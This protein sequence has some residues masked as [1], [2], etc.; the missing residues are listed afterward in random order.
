MTSAQDKLNNLIPIE[1]NSSSSRQD[2]INATYANNLGNKL[3]YFIQQLAFNIM[4]RK[5]GGWMCVPKVTWTPT[6]VTSLNC[7]DNFTLYGALG[8]STF[9]KIANIY[10]H[11]VQVH[12]HYLYMRSQGKFAKRP[13]Q[14][15]T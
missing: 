5:K 7:S 12:K 4:R 1:L 13:L 8:N 3:L 11:N 9:L 15:S 6:T 10:A 2:I 14:P